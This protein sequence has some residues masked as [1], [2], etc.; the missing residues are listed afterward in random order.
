MSYGLNAGFRGSDGVSSHAITIPTSTALADLSAGSIWIWQQVPN[1]SNSVRVLV[2]K[3]VTK[4]G[5]ELFRRG[6]NGSILRFGRYRA[7]TDLT[8]DSP[9]STIRINIPQFFFVSWDIA[10]SGN[11]RMYAGDLLTPAAAVSP[12]VTLGSGAPATD[13]A[14]DILIG[15]GASTNGWPGVIWSCGI[16]GRVDYTLDEIRRLQS[17]LRPSAVRN[18]AGLWT[19]DCVP[20]PNLLG[21]GEIGTLTGTGRLSPDCLPRVRRVDMAA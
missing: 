2:N 15:N 21:G 1:V 10:T 6:T 4:G 11:C 12:T 16:S 20:C 5:W 9:A 18:G 7:T 8:I 17:D 3:S 14:K 19:F 13:A